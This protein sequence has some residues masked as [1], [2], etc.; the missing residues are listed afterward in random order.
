[1][2]D[3]PNSP[4][5]GQTVT[6]PSNVIYS[7]DGTKWVAVGV[8]T[9]GSQYLPV[10]GGTMIGPLTLNADPT[11]TLQAATKQYVDNTLSAGE[12][13]YLP[14]AGGTMTGALTINAAPAAD[15]GGFKRLIVLTDP[16]NN[17]P[18]VFFGTA[19]NTGY[20]LG[21]YNGTMYMSAYSNT[22]T[23]YGD[24]LHFY[25]LGGSGTV[26]ISSGTTFYLDVD[27]TSPTEAATKRYADKMLP[28]TGGTISGNLTVTGS[29]TTTGGVDVA[30]MT[31]SMTAWLNSLPTAPQATKQWWNN[32]GSPVY[33]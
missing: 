25:R 3:F 7:W 9:G 15:A 30:S 28:L 13:A 4:T 12:G 24:V 26:T 2:F 10:T 23:Y 14:L 27:P 32:G 8:T 6:G 16:A 29:I 20:T 11:T 21:N 31:T 22:G 19:N 33:S 1:M 18:G 5:N 17:H